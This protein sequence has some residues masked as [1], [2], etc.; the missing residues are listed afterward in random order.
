MLQNLSVH[1]VARNISSVLISTPPVLSDHQNCDNSGWS[2]QVESLSMVC[3]ICHKLYSM[4]LWAQWM[5]KHST[6]QVGQNKNLKPD[7]GGCLFSALYSQNC[8]QPV[9]DINEWRSSAS[10]LFFSFRKLHCNMSGKTIL[11]R[12]LNKF[13]FE[14]HPNAPEDYYLEVV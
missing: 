2:R 11:P 9:D 6:K 13:S 5:V 12:Y 14:M 7:S 4:K 10:C 1:L 3:L 8:Q